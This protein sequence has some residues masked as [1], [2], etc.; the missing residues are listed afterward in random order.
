MRLTDYPKLQ[1]PLYNCCTLFL[2]ISI[3]ILRSFLWFTNFITQRH[4]L[5]EKKLLD[6]I[7]RKLSTI[8]SKQQCTMQYLLDLMILNAQN[9][10]IW[11]KFAL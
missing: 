1:P 7:F 10:S 6:Q 4:L 2:G 11:N 5:K 3:K 9:T 8:F